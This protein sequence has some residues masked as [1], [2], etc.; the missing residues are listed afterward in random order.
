M[1]AAGRDLMSQ[2]VTALR[3]AG[4]VFAE[5]EARLLLAAAAGP[6]EL[7]ELVRRRAG[8]LP[9]EVLLGWADFC[10]L[11]VAVEAGV[12][13]PRQ[14]S[15]F[16]VEQ[17]VACA[18]PGSV[19]VDLCCGTGAVGLAMLAARE[20]LRLHCRR[21]RSGRG[22]VRRAQPRRHRRAGVCR[23]PVPAAAG[24]AAGQRRGAGCQRA[25]RAHRR[26]WT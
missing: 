24:N 15:A 3:A 9:L 11:R 1:S 7:A 21:P 2:T 18:R 6:A 17:A 20:G 23:R 19:V 8:G 25:V 12:F 26:P 22:P 13:V 5:D 10:G 4:C 16:L 14:R